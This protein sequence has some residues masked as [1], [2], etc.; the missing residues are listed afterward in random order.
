M[1][2]FTDL[3]DLAS[4]KN[5]GA[6]L[7]ANDEFFA[8]KENLLR[9]HPAVW[10]EHRYTDRGKWMDGWETRRRRVAGDD[11]CIVRLGLPGVVRGVVVDTSYFRGN[12]P[13]ACAIEAAVA[14]AGTPPEAIEGWTEL[15]P[16]VA[17]EGN[18]KNSFP[19]DAPFRVTHLRLRIYPDGGV[20]RLRVHGDVVPDWKRLLRAPE[21]DLAT[22]ENGAFVPRVSD[23]FFGSRNNLIAPGRPANMGEGWETRRRRGPG[24]DWAIVRLAGEGSVRLAEI[25]TTHFRGNAPGWCTLET[26]DGDAWTELLPRTALLSNTRHLFDEALL[27]VPAATHVRLQI[28]PDGGVARLRLFGSLSPAGRRG[29]GVRRLDTALHPEA[30]LRACCASSAWVREM[31][32]RRPFGTL[33]AV[34]A[35]ADEVWSALGPAD[36]R[37]SMDGHPRIGER[38]AGWSDQEQA[39]ARGTS[40]SDANRAYEERFGHIFLVCATGKTGE[41]ILAQI[42]ARMT[43]G[44]EVE[45]RV[46]AEEQRQITRLRLAKLLS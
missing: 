20:A 3:I 33:D 8:E 17:L 44:P 16:R 46:A 22:A 19:V 2:E 15:L 28:F 25:D 11:W 26:G 35:A 9:S 39:S 1:A 31:A 42:A 7:S 12:Y 5:G 29:V 10:D 24:N 41:Q 34:L 23:M 6:V 37:E 14:E 27:A 40:F 21:L 18:A 43:N 13:E 45:L 4:E 36:W 30:E 38:R 32:A